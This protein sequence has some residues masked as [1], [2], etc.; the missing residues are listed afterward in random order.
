LSYFGPCLASKFP[1]CDNK[2]PKNV[3]KNII[4]VSKTEEFYIHRKLAEKVIHKNVMEKSRFLLLV[5]FVKVSGYL[6]CNISMDKLAS[7]SAF[8]IPML[9]P[10]SQ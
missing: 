2:A 6:F 4:G 10:L 8:L 9:I 3:C 5:L 7:N 1:K